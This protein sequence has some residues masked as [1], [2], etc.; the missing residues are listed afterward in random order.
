MATLLR[1]CGAMYMRRSFK[2]DKVYGAIFKKYVQTVIA[3]GD[4]PFEFFIE[5]TRS[6]CGKS[7]TPKLGRYWNEFR[8]VFY[9]KIFSHLP[10]CNK[11]SG[12]LKM[13]V[14]VYS[15]KLVEDITFVPISINYERLIEDRLFAREMLGIPKPKESTTVFLLLS[16]NIF[17]AWQM[18]VYFSLFFLQGMLKGI[19]MLEEQY[20]NIYVNFGKEISLKEFSHQNQPDADFLPH[21]AHLILNR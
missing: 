19:S 1:R 20:G 12:L 16:K 11:I 2:D 17:Y 15:M 3:M 14:E 6:R 18:S 8:R 5:G 13:V 21:L 4:S 7:L 10:N 9:V